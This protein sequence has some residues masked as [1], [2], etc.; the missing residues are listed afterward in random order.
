MGIVTELL[1]ND[2]DG[3][4]RRHIFRVTQV[5]GYILIL[6]LMLFLTGLTWRMFNGAE[7]ELFGI[8]VANPEKTENIE[9]PVRRRDEPISNPS[10]APSSP[11][12]P[13][14]STPAPI[15]NASSWYFILGDHIAC[16]NATRDA[17]GRAQLNG[18]Q[19]DSN[20]FVGFAMKPGA[21]RVDVFTRCI[22]L[23]GFSLAVYNAISTQAAASGEVLRQIT[24]EFT[25]RVGPIAVDKFVGT[26]D[27]QFEFYNWQFT[28]FPSVEACGSFAAQ[29]HNRQ[30][31]TWRRGDGP[32]I[33]A[34]VGSTRVTTLCIKDGDRVSIITATNGFSQEEATALRDRYAKEF[35][36][37]QRR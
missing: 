34:F 12:V 13:A 19:G 27:R 2:T 26:T 20:G 23:N 5:A 35:V 32:A 30:N 17:L 9:L 14:T 10:L 36:P 37:M 3:K 7:V 8:R 24:T 4:L 21:V 29:V 16:T 28:T 11:S 15:Q 22:S 31:P 25:N 18:F 1:A 33:F 6:G